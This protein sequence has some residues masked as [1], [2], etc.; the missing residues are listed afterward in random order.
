G[1]DARLDRVVLKT[2]EKDPGKRYQSAGDLKT[3]VETVARTGGGVPAGRGGFAGRRKI[4]IA[5]AVL[6]LAGIAA[7][8]AFWPK[9]GGSGAAGLEA[10][11]LAAE[12]LDPRLGYNEKEKQWEKIRSARAVDRMLAYFERKSQEEPQNPE[13]EYLLGK[14]C[15]N[16]LF[17]ADDAEKAVLGRKADEAF[18]RALALDPGHWEARF[19]KALCLT[20]WPAFLGKQGEC[21]RELETLIAQQEKSPPKQ[22][23][24][25][26]Y[27][28]LGNLYLQQ[29]ARV[30]ALRA[31]E[32]GLAQ[33]PGN[34]E[35]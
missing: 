28:V 8:I 35:L 29:G 6:L 14:A 21:L 1:V 5:A 9:T 13:L 24:V 30:K 19:T 17:A 34:A 3:D 10:E 12:L 33:F 27:V 18:A 23:F 11:A 16:K 4:A 7:G 32:R 22:K 2:L 31:W 25:Q 20:Y 26:A 15:I